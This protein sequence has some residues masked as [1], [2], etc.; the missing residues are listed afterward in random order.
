MML[1]EELVYFVFS[2]L[3]KCSI[4]VVICYFFPISHYICTF[5]ACA[6]LCKSI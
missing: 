5:M 4:E 3:A 1:D 2:D 6:E